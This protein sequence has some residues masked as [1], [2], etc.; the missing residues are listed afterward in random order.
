MAD[1]ALVKYESR[2]HGLTPADEA[3]WA[4]FKGLVKTLGDGEMVRVH[5]AQPRNT[6]FHRKF[7]AL[8]NVGFEHWNPGRTRKTYKGLPV[9]K[10]FDRF[11]ED[12]TILAGYY[13]QTYDLR[14]RMRLQ[15]KSISF[16]KMEQAD[17]EALY[18]SVANVL[19]QHILQNYK[20]EDL[21]E[22][23][24]KLIAFT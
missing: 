10:N 5:Y 9:E 18:D 14:G 22:V 7:F 17:F 16:A 11:R 20:R 4:R 1:I 2:L 15:A 21:D 24:E 13:E 23:V 3:A 6:K 8:L 19:L 12:I